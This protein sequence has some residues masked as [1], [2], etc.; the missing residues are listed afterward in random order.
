VG[1]SSA[2]EDTALARRSGRRSAQPDLRDKEPVWNACF[3]MYPAFRVRL[4]Q[5]AQANRDQNAKLVSLDQIPE[6]A[7][8]VPVDDDDWFC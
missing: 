3:S 4:M 5:I 7:P 6:A 1:R 2:S 8:M